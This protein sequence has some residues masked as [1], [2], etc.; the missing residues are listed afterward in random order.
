MPS[1]V[2]DWGSYLFLCLGITIQKTLDELYIHTYICTYICV[3]IRIYIYVYIYI[4]IHRYMYVYIYISHMYISIYISYMKDS[5]HIYEW[6]TSY[7]DVGV[8]VLSEALSELCHKC[9]LVH[10]WISHVTP[11]D[12]SFVYEWE[13]EPEPWINHVSTPRVC[14]VKRLH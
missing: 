8:S 6:F 2:S 12:E 1:N 3:Y 10:I 13:S 14:V 5:C 7:R 9:E 4:Y 11:I